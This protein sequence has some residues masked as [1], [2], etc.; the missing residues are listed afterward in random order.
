MLSQP[1]VDM[2][3]YYNN[4]SAV[5]GLLDALLRRKLD[6]AMKTCVEDETNARLAYLDIDTAP[7]VD[8]VTSDHSKTRS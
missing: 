4:G 6:A 2:L 8:G 7:A 1:L 5:E 3:D